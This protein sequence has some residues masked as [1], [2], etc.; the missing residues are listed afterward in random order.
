MR[1][2]TTLFS[3]MHSNGSVIIYTFY[4]VKKEL[5]AQVEKFKTLTGNFPGRVDG[6]QHLHV[7]PVIREVFAEV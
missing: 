6:H 4:Q 7:F 2:S 3:S 1:R 5:M